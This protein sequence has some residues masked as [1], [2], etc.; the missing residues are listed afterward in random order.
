MNYPRAFVFALIAY[1]LVVIFT[2]FAAYLVDWNI[3]DPE[4]LEKIPNDMQGLIIIGVPLITGIVASF[5][6]SNITVD[7]SRMNGLI[8]GLIVLGVGFVLDLILINF[9]H[10]KNP[11]G[12][13]LWSYY[14]NAVFYLTALFMLLATTVAARL[15]EENYA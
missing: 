5:Y 11:E 1:I 9:Y 6:F 13:N 3:F 4:V 15:Q 10:Y 14:G 12:A 2:P 7:A 8:F